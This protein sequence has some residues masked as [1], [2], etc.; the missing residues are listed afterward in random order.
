MLS[1]LRSFY[2]RYLANEQAAYLI[3]ALI[4]FVLLVSAFSYLLMPVLISVVIAYLLNW[5]VAT[6][7]KRHCPR[8]VAVTIVFVFFISLVL[9]IIFALLPLLI[10]QLSSFITELPQLG[11]KFHTQIMHV[12]DRI[13]FIS[14]QQIHYALNES[15][16]SLVNIGKV[17]LSSSIASIPGAISFVVYFVMVPLLVYFFLMDQQKINHWCQRFIPKNRSAL[18][19]VW[20]ELDQQLS[21]YVRGKVLEAIIVAITS[22]AAFAILGLQYAVLLAVLVGLSVFIP[23]IGAIVVTIP[24]VIIALLQWGFQPHFFY[25]MAVYGLIIALDGTVLVA[26]LFSEAVSIHPVAIIVATLVF[27]GIW[28]F[29]GVFFAIPLA[30][31]LKAL[32]KYWPVNRSGLT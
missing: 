8:W 27:G 1:V 29:W 30:S 31:L 12:I 4:I 25:L 14:E 18:V 6:L 22:Y 16:Q 23:Y 9:L 17:I 2:Q 3:I 15:R 32:I 26:I 24:I 13:P 11:A 28:G 5:G 7:C 19:Q 20:Q 10:Q 21:N